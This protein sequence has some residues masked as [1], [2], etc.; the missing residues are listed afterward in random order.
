MRGTWRVLTAV[1][2]AALLVGCGDDDTDAE[3][4]DTGS[5]DDVEEIDESLDSET[6]GGESAEEPAQ[7]PDPPYEVQPGDTLSGIA[8][9]FDVTVDELIEA[10]ELDD[11]DVLAEGQ[12]LVIP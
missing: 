12:E 2:L 5:D 1:L 6:G 7:D 8:K 11:P 3:E 10:N 4:A 9:E